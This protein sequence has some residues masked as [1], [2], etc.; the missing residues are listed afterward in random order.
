[1]CKICVAGTAALVCL[2]AA[3]AFLSSTEAKA[4]PKTPAENR[5]SP[6]T[7][8]VPACDH[9]RV[10]DRIKSRFGQRERKYWKTGREI[11][12]FRHPREIGYRSNGS[13]FIP[14][15]WCSVRAEFNDGRKRRVTYSIGEDLGMAGASWLGPWSAGYGIGWG[16]E[17][18]VHG[19]DY[20]LAYAPGCSAA[21]P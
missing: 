19:L 6:Y 21:A 8:T 1:M 16:V 2:G 17:W 9:P 15:R 11:V 5:Y 13:D 18:C 12:G 4:R 20:N 3:A 10:L 7:G 14:R